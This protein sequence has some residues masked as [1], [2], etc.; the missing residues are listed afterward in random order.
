M[1]VKNRLNIIAVKKGTSVFPAG[2]S[3]YKEVGTGIPTIAVREGQFVAY[4][5]KDKISVD[6]STIGDLDTVVF[7][8]GWGRN[9]NTGY[10]NEFRKAFMEETR[11]CDLVSGTAEPFKCGQAAVV[12]LLFDCIQPDTTNTIRIE[13]S[14]YE[15]DSFNPEFIPEKKVYTASTEI[16]TCTPECDPDYD[17]GDL[18]D[19]LIDQINGEST[20]PAMSGNPFRRSPDRHMPVFA[21]KIFANSFQFCM[22]AVDESDCN[23]CTHIPAILGIKIGDGEPIM[24]EDTEDPE[25]PGKTMKEQLP[26]IK[27]LVDAALVD[28]EGKTIGTMTY[29]GSFGQCCPTQIEINTSAEDV[30]FIGENGTEIVNCGT[31]SPLEGGYRCGIRVVAKEIDGDCLCS[32]PANQYVKNK[33]RRI[34]I[35]AVGDGWYYGKVR[36][37]HVQKPKP[38]INLGYDLVEEDYKSQTGGSGRRHLAYNDPQGRF[39]YPTADSR[40]LN[41]GIIDCRAGYC[42][43]SLLHNAKFPGPFEK[44]ANGIPGWTKV[45]IQMTDTE[46]ILAI[47]KI[48]N[49]FI[50]DTTCPIFKSLECIDSEGQI[51]TPDLEQTT[52][53]GADTV[54]G[55]DPAEDETDSQE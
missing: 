8:V 47:Q 15:S 28:E 46:N 23:K 49:A 32:L 10:A 30:V 50:A 42:I 31:S 13:V 6:E 24:F 51:L 34:N 21:H 18:V 9:P 1:G 36:V 11:K 26:M 40:A 44:Y 43:L 38:P 7:A 29:T 39:N 54:H 20:V 4:D 37:N 33:V 2:Q 3:I 52:W 25:N 27:S 12:D 14:D 19:S 5:P 35:E 17:C 41:T 55:F 45:A 16:I 48:I 53:G 22:D